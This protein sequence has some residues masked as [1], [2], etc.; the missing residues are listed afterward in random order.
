MDYERLRQ[1]RKRIVGT[2]QTTKAVQRNQVKVVYV[3]ADAEEKVVGPLLA[4]CKEKNVEVI[5]VDS[6]AEL[7]KA[8]GIQVGSAAAAILEEAESQA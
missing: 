5:T 7:G 4:L 1:A 3:A 8:C 6:M 2:K